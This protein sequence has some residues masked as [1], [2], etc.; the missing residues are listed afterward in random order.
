MRIF[1]LIIVLLGV[2]LGTGCGQNTPV[3]ASTPTRE[4]LAR[5]HFVGCAALKTDADAAKLR[6]IWAMPESKVFLED[7][8]QKLARVPFH[9]AHNRVADATNNQATLIR[10]MLDDLLTEESWAKVVGATNETPEAVFAIRLDDERAKLWSANLGTILSD[11]T[12]LKL[13]PLAAGWELKKHHAPNLISVVRAGGWLVIGLGQDKLPLH[14]EVLK[15]IKTTGQ[16]EIVTS[17]NWLSFWG[18]GPRLAAWLS[19]STPVTLPQGQLTLFGQG[20]NL[21]AKVV[22]DFPQ[23]LHLSPQPWQIPTNFI[24]EP[25]TAFTAAQGIAPWL[26]RLPQLQRFQ[27]DPLPDQLC[28]WALGQFPFQTFVAAPYA[29]PSNLI[30]RLAPQFVA[31]GKSNLPPAVGSIRATTNF[32]SVF[33]QGLPLVIPNLNSYAENNGN[34]LVFGLFPN[35][36]KPERMPRELLEQIVG[37]TNQVYYD[38]ELTENRLNDWRNLGQLFRIVMNGQTVSTNAPGQRWLIALG[39]KLGNTVTE[40][41]VTAPNQLTLTRRSHSGFT[42]IELVALSDWL[43]TT[44]FPTIDYRYHPRLPLPEKSAPPAKP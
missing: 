12:A 20:D 9:L 28:M 30:A 17:T 34:Y 44:N 31:L 35:S 24:R 43:E 22:L 16:P 26:K 8:L 5:F 25:L 41:T 27:I 10:S 39:P 11:W 29:N 23:P 33:W 13:T 40:M 6:Q 7:T 36:Q 18:N 2:G 1:S 14:E 19:L 38:W 32:S 21:R 3:N 42:G 15:R 37:H 4:M